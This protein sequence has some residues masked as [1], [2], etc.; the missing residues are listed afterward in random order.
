MSSTIQRYPSMDNIP[1]NFTS[2]KVSNSANLLGSELMGREED[3]V[4]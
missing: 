3:G 1:S 2:N 4:T